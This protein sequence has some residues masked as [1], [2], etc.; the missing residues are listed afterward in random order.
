MFGNYCRSSNEVSKRPRPKAITEN[1]SHTLQSDCFIALL[2]LWRHS[3]KT[4]CSTLS[5]LLFEP[6]SLVAPTLHAFQ[7][8]QLVSLSK[9]VSIVFSLALSSPGNR[10]LVQSCPVA[11]WRGMKGR[12]DGKT[13]TT[14]KGSGTAAAASRVQL[15]PEPIRSTVTCVACAMGI[16]LHPSEA[17]SR[18]IG[19]RNGLDGRRSRG[20]KDS[21]T[22]L[23]WDA[24]VF[25]LV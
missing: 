23:R 5:T 8:N 14:G 20:R 25:L 12:K 11:C 18:A 7:G 10:N 24:I 21:N 6:L 3:S 22:Y 4:V 13:A 15:K 16:A 1:Q 19:G 9:M 2:V 17:I